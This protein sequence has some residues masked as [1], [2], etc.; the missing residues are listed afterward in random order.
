MQSYPAWRKKRCKKNTARA[1]GGSDT[2]AHSRPTVFM[3]FSPRPRAKMLGVYPHSSITAS[4]RCRVLALTRSLPL[5]TR[6]TVAMDTPARL[7]IS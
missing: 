6:D 5:S 7:D 1:M 2:L 4:T 3:V